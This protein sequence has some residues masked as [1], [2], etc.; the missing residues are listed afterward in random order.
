MQRYQHN[1][2][3]TPT[4]K[5]DYI[6]KSYSFKNRT[7]FLH[8]TIKYGNIK[9]ICFCV[10]FRIII[11]GGDGTICQAMTSAVIQ[12]QGAYV[13]DIKPLNITLGTIPTGRRL[14]ICRSTVIENCTDFICFFH[15]CFTILSTTFQL[16]VT[17]H[18][19]SCDR[20]RHDLLLSALAIDSRHCVPRAPVYEVS[21]RIHLFAYCLHP[22]KTMHFTQFRRCR[23]AVYKLS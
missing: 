23:N 18:R 20:E 4:I 13:D 2:N 7:T 15:K 17:L 22:Y 1:T 19:C 11:M 12:E 6:E 14:L 3:T 8:L 10:S 16:C 9:L 21:S 5:F